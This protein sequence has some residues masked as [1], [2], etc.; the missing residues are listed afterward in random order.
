ME[1]E[2][3]KLAG[4]A[5]L[6]WQNVQAKAFRKHGNRRSKR[7]VSAEKAVDICL[8][9]TRIKIVCELHTAGSKKMYCYPLAIEGRI[10]WRGR[11][12]WYKVTE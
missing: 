7:H 3:S 9:R 5:N 10:E 6:K 2:A 12:V 1:S 11:Q 4:H 8:D